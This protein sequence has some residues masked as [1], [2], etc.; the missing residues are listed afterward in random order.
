LFVAPGL[1]LMLVGLFLVVWLLPGARV[2]GSVTFDIHTMFFGLIF[3]LLGAQMV[4]TGL[5]ARVFSYSEQ[6][7]RGGK[8]FES[9]LKRV[10]L[11]QGL[12][13]GGLVT[14]AGFAGCV[15]VFLDWRSTGYGPFAAQRPVIFWSMLLFLGVQA[16]LSSVFLSML[17]ISRDTY[18]GEYDR[19]EER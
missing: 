6:F 13:V 19:R 1:A 17:G 8:S 11:E 2:V 16:I 9:A 4:W 15:Y 10:T 18:I 5:F 14:A 12:V 3:T 7:S